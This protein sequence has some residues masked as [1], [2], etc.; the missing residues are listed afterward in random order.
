MSAA[1]AIVAIALAFATV[2]TI[3]AA[4]YVAAIVL[5]FQ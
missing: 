2:V 5:V 1:Q 4:P 3:T